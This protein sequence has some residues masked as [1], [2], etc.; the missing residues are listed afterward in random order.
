M[1][2]N[3]SK[4]RILLNTQNPEPSVDVKVEGRGLQPL[5]TQVSFQDLEVPTITGTPVSDVTVNTTFTINVADV[6]SDV[7]VTPYLDGVLIED[8]SLEHSNPVVNPSGGVDIEITPRKQ[9]RW[10]LKVS[11]DSFADQEIRFT[12]APA[13]TV[14]VVPETGTVV[15]ADKTIVIEITNTTNQVTVVSLDPDVTVTPRDPHDPD[16]KIFEITTTS[17]FTITPRIAVRGIGVNE[18][19]FTPTFRQGDIIQLSLQEKD[20]RAGTTQVIKVVGADP[21]RTLVAEVDQAHSSI[22]TA[23]VVD[24]ET[25]EVEATSEVSGAVVTVKGDFIEETTIEVSFRP[26]SDTITY[27][28]SSSVVGS[29]LP[30]DTTTY[31]GSYITIN[32]EGTKEQ[33]Q[34]QSNSGNTIIK[35]GR[36]KYE[37]IITNSQV[38]DIEITVTGN[39]VNTLTIPLSFVDRQVGGPQ[40]EII[41]DSYSVPVNT[42]GFTFSVTNLEGTLKAKSTSFKVKPVVTGNVVELVLSDYFPDPVSCEIILS[43]DGQ[44]DRIVRVDVVFPEELKTMDFDKRTLEFNAGSSA[45]F[46]IPTLD[47]DDVVSIQPSSPLLVYKLDVNVVTITSNDV[48]DYTL[49]VKHSEY[50]DAVLYVSVKDAS[51]SVTPP[52]PLPTKEEYYDLGMA[53]D[54]SVTIDNNG[55]YSSVLDSKL[56]TSDKE[57]LAYILE[58]GSIGYTANLHLML[59]YEEMTGPDAP[60]R[61]GEYIAKQN[62]TL[63]HTLK[64]MLGAVDYYEFKGNLRLILKVFKFY[65]DKSYSLPYLLRFDDK[66]P[67]RDSDLESFKQLCTWLVKYV[68]VDGANMGQYVASLKNYL[69][70]STTDN[71]R[72]FCSQTIRP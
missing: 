58:N 67:G 71:L 13:D 66:W 30:N 4:N 38:E 57:K 34:F 47:E 43:V 25:I 2:K 12:A 14:V 19:I 60:F 8:T 36:S 31:V 54:V 64:A 15:T 52:P 24:T 61:G 40:F 21:S 9:G 72:Q 69:P 55:F 53:P 70:E 51:A 35:D 32:V 23:N 62:Y 6:T 1:S 26:T 45:K 27:T 16:N 11:G 17:S 22:V 7:V 65:H 29:T 50:K 59:T 37:K 63:F 39:G 46:A 5:T 68:E 20:P 56:I 42:K 28:A 3:K 10:L 41:H 18:E 33:L 44:E 48:G 49:V